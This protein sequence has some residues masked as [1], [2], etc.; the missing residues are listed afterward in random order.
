MDSFS[1]QLVIKALDGLAQRA[2]V[3]AQNIANGGT[4]GYRPFRLTFETALSQAAGKGEAAVRAVKPNIERAPVEFGEDG[5]R[6]D[7]ELATA[8]ST[9]L[10]YSA[11]VD[12]LNRQMQINALAVAGGN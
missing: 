2:T 1:A 10:R 9:A 12:L 7:L 11:L 6:L 5:M 3:T 8:S 4:P